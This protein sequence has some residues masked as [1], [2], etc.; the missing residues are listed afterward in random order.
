MLQGGLQGFGRQQRDLLPQPGDLH[1]SG[2]AQHAGGQLGGSS[3]RGA[4]ALEFCA[5]LG[6]VKG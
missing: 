1:G 3:Q 6:D 4:C 5:G 2:E